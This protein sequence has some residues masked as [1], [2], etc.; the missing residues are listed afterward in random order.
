MELKYLVTG[1]PRS[2][3]VYMARLLT[4]MGLM[5]G[6]ES[7]FTPDGLNYAIE[8]L[9]GKKTANTSYVSLDQELWFNPQLQ[10]AESSYLAAP[11]LDHECLNNCS[12]IHII[13]NPLKVISSI[14]FDA[15]FF[16]EEIQIPY[17]MLVCSFLPELKQINNEIEKVV[18]F[19]VWWNNLIE[20]KSLGKHYIRLN[21]ETTPDCELFNF[22][23]IQ[24]TIDF[25]DNKKINSWKKR[26]HNLNLFDIPDGNI[27]KEFIKKYEYKEILL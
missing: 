13:R 1:L 9:K 25:F 19:Y 27:K 12:I 24:P 26:T 17:R 20:Q 5:C 22:I 18:A 21:I 11:F 23:N 4:S 16:N 6:H 8:T 2:G 10:I 3:T 7:I 15:N 14:Y